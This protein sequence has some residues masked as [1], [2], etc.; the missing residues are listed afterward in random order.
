MQREIKFRGW[1][2]D[3]MLSLS[4]LL[5]GDLVCVQHNRADGFLLDTFYDFVNLMQFT[6]L[7][8]KNGVEVYES[9]VIEFDSVNRVVKFIH[10]CWMLE[11]EKGYYI[12]AHHYIDV[13]EVI[14][15]IYENKE[16]LEKQ[17]E[18]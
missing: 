11:R 5:Y 10:G 18:S 3:E 6:G 13:C 7:K 4:E 15:N 17:N 1:D 14:G 12:N 2:G 9:D 16:L 8:D